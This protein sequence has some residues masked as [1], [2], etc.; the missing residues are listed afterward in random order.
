MP[1]G[2]D[3]SGGEKWTLVKGKS[4]ARCLSFVAKRYARESRANNDNLGR[5][6]CPCH[7]RVS[8]KVFFPFPRRN[9]RAIF[10]AAFDK[11]GNQ[12]PIQKIHRSVFAVKRGQNSES[13]AGLTV[14]RIKFLLR[15]SISIVLS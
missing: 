14:R 10:G 3:G 5:K 8:V 9:L 6:N 11:I 7:N 1:F 15:Q 12:R 4:F 13:S 2:T